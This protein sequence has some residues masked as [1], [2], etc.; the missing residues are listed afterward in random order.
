MAQVDEIPKPTIN[1]TVLVRLP[2]WIYNNSWGKYF[3][4]KTDDAEMQELLG[5]EQVEEEADG[6][7]ATLKSAAQT[8]ANAE[9]R[10]RKIKPRKQ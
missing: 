3:G 6:D 1:D 10:K 8:N 9:A 7:M 2:I 4:K 5:D